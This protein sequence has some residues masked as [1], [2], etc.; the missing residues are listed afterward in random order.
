MSSLTALLVLAAG[1]LASLSP[2]A[3]DPPSPE[4]GSASTASQAPDPA[5]ALFSPPPPGAENPAAGGFGFGLGLD[6][7]SDEQDGLG[8]AASST[9]VTLRNPDGSEQTFVRPGDPELEDRK[10]GKEISFRGLGIQAPV[11][12]PS[13]SLGPAVAVYPAIVLEASL[14]ETEVEIVPLTDPGPTASLEGS[15]VMLG[16][17]IDWVATACRRCRL[18]WGGGY[19]YR[20]LPEMELDR[21]VLAVGPGV[22]VRGEELHLSAESHRVAARVGYAFRGGRFAPYLG[23]RYR[24][25]DLELEDELR[26]E[27]PILGQETELDTRTDLEGEGAAAVLGLDVT[28]AERYAVRLEAAIGEDE[29][30]ALVK[31]VRFLGNAP[32]RPRAPA[33]RVEWLL[34]HGPQL[35]IARRWVEAEGVLRGGWPVVVE[36]VLP[37]EGILRL[38]IEAPDHSEIIHELPGRAGQRKSEMRELP[39]SLGDDLVAGRFRLEAVSGEGEEIPFR[40]LALGAGRGAIASAAISDVRLE[41]RGATVAEYSFRLAHQF[42]DAEAKFL[43]WPDD[44]GEA[45]V[46]EK[47][48]EAFTPPRCVLPRPACRGQWNATRAGLYVLQ[49]T[50][51]RGDREDGD[52]VAAVSFEEA[53]LGR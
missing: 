18:F 41:A 12:I 47:P 30:S 42:S 15:G 2:P 35:V 3:D 10:F 43:R 24:T 46:F 26:L 51:W 44:A 23:A 5:E 36:Y 9:T 8:T 50:A 48:H 52:W 1:V 53:D 19:R 27:D 4:A 28:V 45:S 34:E 37:E 13:F 40:F 17:G 31:V 11:A 29:T 33:S 32:G 38:R 49:V 39:A 20:F 14:V 6:L 25:T 21:S 16:L 7:L 22:K